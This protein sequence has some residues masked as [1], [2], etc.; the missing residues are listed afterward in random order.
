M[1]FYLSEDASKDFADSHF[2]YP[3]VL[4]V[5]QSQLNKFS[6]VTS[7]GHDLMVAKNGVI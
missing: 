2:I 5:V 3:M 7:C 6:L 4:K 1:R